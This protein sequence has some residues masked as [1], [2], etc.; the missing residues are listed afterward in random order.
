MD[1][2]NIGFIDYRTLKPEEIRTLSLE[3]LDGLDLGLLSAEHLEVVDEMYARY[4]Y[5]N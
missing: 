5:K 3:Q 1:R 4:N 2:V